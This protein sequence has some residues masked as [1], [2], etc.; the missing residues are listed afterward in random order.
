[1]VVFGLVCFQAE[2][3]VAH[4]IPCCQLPEHHAK[5]L[6]P[7]SKKS[8]I[9]IALVFAYYSIEYPTGQKFSDLS[10]DVFALIHVF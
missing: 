7:A 5:H 10:E 2:H 1:M 3:Q 8:Y 6:I 9:L 4:A